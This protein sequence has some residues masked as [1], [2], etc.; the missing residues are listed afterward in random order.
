M[1]KVKAGRK[2]MKR[3][4]LGHGERGILVTPDNSRVVHSCKSDNNIATFDPRTLVSD[5]LHCNRQQS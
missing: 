1:E 2:E 5:G 4:S 3:V